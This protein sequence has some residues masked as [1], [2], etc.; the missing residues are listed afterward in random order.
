MV[1]T[2]DRTGLAA[3][4]I[5]ASETLAKLNAGRFYT[6]DGMRG[7]AAVVVVAFHA[8][9]T[10]GDGVPRF[11]YMAVDLFFV[12]SGFVIARAYDD[13]LASGMT[14]KEFAARRF[15]RLFPMMLVGSLLGLLAPPALNGTN[16]A[17]STVLNSLG[18]PGIPTRLAPSLTPLNP[19]LWSL[20]F[21]L[22]VANLSY[23]LFS[24]ILRGRWLAV[25]VVC[26]AVAMAWTIHKT[27]WFNVGWGWGWNNAPFGL[28]RVLFG[29][30]AGVG[31]SSL[32]RRYPPPTVPPLLIL[33]ATVV[34]LC[35]PLGGGHL[36]HWIELAIAVLVFPTLVYLGSSIT[37]RNPR[38]GEWLGEASYALYAMHFPLLKASVPLLIACGWV[39]MKRPEQLALQTTQVIALVCVAFALDKWPD[40]PAQEWLRR[41]ILRRVSPPHHSKS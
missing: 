4:N 6:L 23:A 34:I 31:L 10:M 27:G 2:S 41:L 15:C 26:S 33:A 21:E 9:E 5:E 24:R 22:Y 25:L 32:H 20:F 29:F 40:R 19:A 38:V 13:R 12:L 3:S 1:T 7:V 37:E 28:A 35:A 30:Y 11:G 16:L 17:L 39:A 8:G 36:V 14:F 18:L